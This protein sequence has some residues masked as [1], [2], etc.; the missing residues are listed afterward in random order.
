MYRDF[1][2]IAAKVTEY[3]RKMSNKDARIFLQEIVEEHAPCFE[4]LGFKFKECGFG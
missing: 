1:P 2:F 4:I 3:L